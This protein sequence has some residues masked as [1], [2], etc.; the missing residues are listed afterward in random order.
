MRVLLCHQPTDGGVGRHVRDLIEGLG[1][2]GDIEIAVCAPAVPRGTALPVTHIPLD[3]RRAVA[4]R[5]DAGAARRLARIVRRLR[6]DLIHAHS[7]KAGAVARLARLGAP[8]VPVIYTPHG[9]AFAGY[10]SGRLERRAYL[11]VERG[12]APLTS[13]IVGVCEA[14]ARLARSVASERKIYV[15]HNG[16]EPAPPG[17]PDRRLAELAGDGPLIGALTLLRPGKGLETLLGAMPQVLANHRRAQLAIV[18]EGPDLDALRAQA[19]SLGIGARVHFLGACTEPLAALRGMDLFVHP[20]WAESFPY[21]ILEAMSLGRA[22]VAS[23]V[24]GIGEAV[25]DGESGL[26]VPPRDERALARAMIGLLDERPRRE[27]LGEHA[28]RRVRFFTRELMVSE[29]LTLYE[30]LA[31]RQAGGPIEQMRPGGPPA[32]WRSPQ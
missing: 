15:V 14:E 20:S 12:L 9:F 29:L 17:E 31:A 16:I 8:G 2:L 5:A 10:F 32:R 23:N 18:G 11:E 22:I 13:C 30:Q 27:R 28:L 19:R 24:G 3:L 26:L 7:S 25:V 4:P 21:V 6:P 1:A